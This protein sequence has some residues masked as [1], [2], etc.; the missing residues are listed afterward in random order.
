MQTPLTYSKNGLSLTEQFESCD[1]QAYRDV[2]G[3]WT[4]GYGHTGPEVHAGVVWTQAQAIAALM[5]DVK[6]AAA[7]VNKLVRPQITQDEFDALVDFVFNV[8][9]GAFSRS[10]VL[11]ELN[12]GDFAAAASALEDWKYAGG[13]VVAGLLRRRLAEEA[14]FRTS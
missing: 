5:N 8:G 7:A 6:K 12:S 4:V 10:Q 2:R 13:K 3:V 11:E 14:L 1:L 9:I